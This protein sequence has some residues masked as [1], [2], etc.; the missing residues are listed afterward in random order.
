M[1]SERTSQQ[2]FVGASGLLF[3]GS[4]ALTAAWCSSMS[5]MG[6]MPMSGGWSMS[7]AWTRMPGQTWPGAAGS[8]VAMWV[9]MMIAMMLP[10]LAP[11]LWR[12]RQDVSGDG[13]KHANWLAALVGAGYFAVWTLV[14]MVIFPLG[15]A[16]AALEMQIAGVAHAVPIAEGAV[17][18]IAGALQFTAWKTCHLACWKEAPDHDRAA[19]ADAS[20]ALRQGLHLGLCCSYSS[21]GLTAVLLAMG[22]MDLRAM[23]LIT[24]AITAE[25]LAPGGEKV[26]RATGAVL[27][28]AGLI[29]AVRAALLV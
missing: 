29:L 6:E 11:T 2:T 15:A 13:R 8:F 22:V 28:G 1:V 26:A 27:I 17:L 25:R 24:A 16:M 23:A 3:I 9:V 20:G 18:L 19:H 10:S 14:G 12:Y 5:A 7:M 21:A 4:A